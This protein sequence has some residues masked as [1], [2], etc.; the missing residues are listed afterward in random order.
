MSAKVIPRSSASSRPSI[1]E[2]AALL[3]TN[4]PLESTMHSPSAAEA[5]TDRKRRSLSRN[6]RCDDRSSRTRLPLAWRAIANRAA[7]AT[8]ATT[9][10]PWIRTEYSCPLTSMRTISRMSPIVG[11]IALQPVSSGG[12]RKRT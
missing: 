5:N 9:V 3:E 8:V 7:N 4:L 6:A 12:S 10:N 11:G 1:L 2:K